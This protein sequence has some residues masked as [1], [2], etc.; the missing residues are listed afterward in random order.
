[1]V[2]GQ[3]A[4]E[5][6]ERRLNIKEGETT[7]DRNFS[8]ERVAC[9]GCCSIAPVVVVDEVIEGKVTPTRVDGLMLSLETEIA[10]E[11]KEA[12]ATEK[13]QEKGV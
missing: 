3:I 8:L 11:Q 9:V 2:G 12:E 6:F 7:P 5:S 10:R 1:M 4:L 13:R